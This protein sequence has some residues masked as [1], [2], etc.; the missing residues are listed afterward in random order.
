MNSKKLKLP[1]SDWFQM[2]LENDGDF[3]LSMT[4]GKESAS[5]SLNEMRRVRAF[6]TDAIRRATKKKK[7]K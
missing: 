1:R 2:E 4:M 5:F 3:P 6:L 7:S